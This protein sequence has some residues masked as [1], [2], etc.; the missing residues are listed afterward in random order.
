MEHIDKRFPG[1][2][3]LQDVRFD[4][5]RGEVHALVGENGAGKSTLMKVLGGIYERDGGLIEYDG[6]P[7]DIRTPMAARQL[8]IGMIHQELNLMGHLTVAQNIF[9]GRE[10]T[11]GPFLDTARANREAA[12]L[13]A[14][15]HLDIPPTATVNTLSVAKQQMVEIVKALSLQSELIVMDEPTAALTES[16]IAELFRFIR[17]LKAQNKGV[18]YISHR[19]EELWEISDRVTVMRDGR[20]IGTAETKNLTR[21]DLITMMVNRVISEERKWASDVPE[22]APILLKVEG[23]NAP[24]VKDV[25]FTLRR[26]EILGFAGLMGA[27]RTETMRALVGADQARYRRIELDGKPL[28]IH[29]PSDAVRARI[30]YLSEDRKAFGLAL[31]LSVA[32]NAALPSLE[33]FSGRLFVKDRAIRRTT[34]EYVDALSIKT[35]GVDRLVRNLSGG[36][37]QKTVLAKWLIR[38]CEVLIFD[39]PTRGVDVGAK[40]E[41][42]ALMRQL[43]KDGKSIIMISSEMPEML[44]MADR[45]LVMCEGRVTGELDVAQATQERI[46]SLATAQEQPDSVN[47]VDGARREAGAYP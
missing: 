38:N 42:Y 10:F 12:A 34:T 46:L 14:S 31:G 43:A 11:R 37:Q 17:N 2:N 15:F 9:I 5:R 39:E 35:P 41:I 26:G 36:N 25:S 4:L 18:I 8:G 22:G 19:L 6:S 44:R 33:A 32:D 1:V 20:T 7:V 16:E 3:A 29:S 13:L 40:S 21:S 45:I 47:A 23:L 27:G 24:R 30:G 28:E